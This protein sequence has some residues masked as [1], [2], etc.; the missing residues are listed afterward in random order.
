MKIPHWRPQWR[1]L[2]DYVEPGTNALVIADT[3]GS[4][5]GRPLATSVGL[6][7]YFAERNHGEF[8]N[9]FM[10][11]SGSSRIQVLRGETLAQKINSINMNDWENNTNL[12]AAFKHILDI[13][14][15]NHVSPEDMPK[16]LTV[17]SDMEIDYCGDHE[18][19]FYEK[20]GRG[21]PADSDTR[22]PTLSSGMWRAA[23][24]CSTRT[25]SA[26]VS[27]W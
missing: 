5:H 27:S 17:I 12:Q 24:M 7:V 6:A 15:R 11:F 19:T 16:S 22:F 18:W 26:R 21:L 25:R 23:T 13:A 8:H 20:T 10:S 14:I 4:M 1:Q 3:S 2:P 9:M